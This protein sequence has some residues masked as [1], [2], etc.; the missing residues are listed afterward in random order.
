M[1]KL[2][3]I[4]LAVCI[5]AAGGGVTVMQQM[6]L[7]PFTKEA[8]A[9]PEEKA[10]A[11]AAAHRKKMLEPPR[12]VTM[13]PLLIPI[14]QGDIV[15]ATIQIQVQLET[16]GDNESIISKQMPRL[17]DAYIRDLHSYVPRLLRK[18]KELDLAALKRRLMI[19]G[20]R[21]IGKGL[22]DGVLVQSALNRKLR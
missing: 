5:L 9:T 17:K 8:E 14:F 7:G 3:I 2:L 6:E 15:A 22:I 19:I 20:S 18:N 11:A 1:P 10:A 16:R 4:I 21:T 12:Y 13:E